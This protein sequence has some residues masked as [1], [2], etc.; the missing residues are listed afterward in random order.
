MEENK[1]MLTLLDKMIQ[2]VFCVKEYTVIQAN[3]A[4]R[5]MFIQPGLD[6]RPLL[7]PSSEEYEQYSG[8][9]LYLSL[10]IGGQ[11]V[12][13]CVQR[14][15]DLDIFE[16]DT[17]SD[18]AALRS[19][20][21]AAGELRKPLGTA[22]SNTAALLEDSENPETRL[23]LAQLNRGLYQIMR[24][25][26]NM[27]DAED[28]SAL[29]RLE[30]VNISGVLKEIIEKSAHMLAY[31]GMELD[32]NGLSEPIYAL[33]DRSQLERAVLNILS[34]AAKFSPKGSCIRVSL[35][36]R[37]RTLRL[38]VQD[39]GSGIAE[40]VM[41]SLFRR[42]LRQPGIE[43][44][45]FGLGLGIRMVHSIALQHGGTLLVSPATTGGT[46]IVMTLAIREKDH[47]RMCRPV[48]PID[49]SGG[50]DHSLV[51]LADVLPAELFDGSF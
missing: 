15:D 18:S 3:A 16:L 11:T 7:N 2:P 34:N 49:Y 37:G 26:G 24:I 23:Q 43:D 27:S 6:I 22:L 46:Q 42:Y 31:S 9:C 12:S 19:L 35:T 25:L 38:T 1:D 45:R 17:G 40:A 8:G 29:C 50:F 13:C 47:N 32:Y 14:L 5:Q 41:T 48:F 39:N 20:A 4:A 30:T 10:S 44:S 51:E 36:R 28:A 33:A 21:L